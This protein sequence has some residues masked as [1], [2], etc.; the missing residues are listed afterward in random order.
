M[1]GITSVLQRY[2]NTG[3]NEEQP[4]A[5]KKGHGGR[6][7]LQR[8]LRLLLRVVG[9]ARRGIHPMTMGIRSPSGNDGQGILQGKIQHG[10]RRQFDLLTFGCGLHAA[11]QAATCRRSDARALTTAS[12]ATDDGSDRRTRADL[13]SRVLTA[14]TALALVL[15]RLHTVRPAAYRDAVQLQHYDRLPGKLART[16]HVH[17]VTFHVIT[18]GDSD[19]AV[20]R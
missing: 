13:F 4:P 14:R 12:K 15:V 3:A 2:S 6:R 8:K 7:A 1:L 5:K 20:N 9:I 18:G 11:A 19:L 17:E 10:F 16:L